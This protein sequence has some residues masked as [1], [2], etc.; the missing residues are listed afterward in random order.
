MGWKGL[1]PILHIHQLKKF[2]DILKFVV[3]FFAANHLAKL[4]NGAIWEM[5]K[6]PLVNRSWKNL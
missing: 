6:M 1:H 4:M 2:E 3:V 5:C